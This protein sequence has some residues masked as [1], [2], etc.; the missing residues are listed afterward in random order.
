M[1]STKFIACILGTIATVWLALA[2]KM[3]GN[4]TMALSVVI[5]GYYGGNSY[6]TGKALSNGKDPNAPV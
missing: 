4:V 2:G 6:V 5:G 3:D 1:T